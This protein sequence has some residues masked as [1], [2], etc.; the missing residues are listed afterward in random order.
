VLVHALWVR[1][2]LLRWGATAEEVTADYPG[3]EI[4]D[5]AMS[6]A[7]MAVT[8]PAAPETVW[9]WLAQMGGDRAG[10]YSWDWLDNNG[11][12][13]AD[14]IMA[15]W[16]TVQVGQRLSRSSAPGQSPGSFTVATVTPARTL[17][18]RSTYALRTGRD[19]DPAAAP[20]NQ[21]WV[22]G[23]WG[24]H[25]RPAAAGGTR[26][27]VRSRS[28]GAPRYFVVPFGW[29]VGEPLH[30]L[31]QTRQFHNLRRRTAHPGPVPAPDDRRCAGTRRSSFGRRI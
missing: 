21:A 5:S 22:D 18:L 13:S 20:T 19:I 14:R 10:W 17:V 6:G 26:L 4:V 12:P 15:Q 23:I 29:L 27:V 2:R 8:L 24:F 3:D 7:T 9:S 28:R 25:L 1:P 30:A 16:Q 11:R 31:M